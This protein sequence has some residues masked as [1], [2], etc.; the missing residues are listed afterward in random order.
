MRTNRKSAAHV[1]LA[2]AAATALAA[3]LAACGSGPEAAGAGDG[4]SEYPLTVVNCG[5]ETVIESEPESVLTIGHSAVALLDAAGAS[6]RI[7][8]RTGEFDAP[9]PEDLEN[10]P[11]E[12]EVIDPADPSAETIIGAGADIVVGYGLFEAAP[13]SLES[14]GIPNLVITGECNNDEAV[15]GSVG[16]DTVFAD[17]ER[18]GEVFGT[19]EAAAASTE[20]LTSELSEMEDSAPGAGRTAAAVYYWSSTATMSAYG[21]LSIAHDILDRAEFDDVYGDE[22][23]AFVEANF[24]TLI[25]AD[26]EVIFLAY[27]VYGEDFETA[28][29]QLLAE[30]GAA[31]LQA[32]KNDLVIGVS[33]GDLNPDP[34]AI[35]GLRAVVE[36]AAQ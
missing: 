17:I 32:V 30:P 2:V 33:A 3:S 10:P 29:A 4:G 7:T 34:G 9:L 35:R 12:V 25:D 28:K 18:F 19:Q 22:Q 16:F 1:P 21:G 5:E 36:G 26:P 13:E 23:S 24:E 14:A 20:R 6:D 31:D 11:T 15:V 27:G 8:A